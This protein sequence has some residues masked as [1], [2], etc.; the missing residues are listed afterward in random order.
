MYS[1]KKIE[2]LVITNNPLK[3]IHTP[4]CGGSY[5]SSILSKLHIPNKGHGQALKNENATTFTVI[6]NPVERFESL[7]NYRLNE[8]NIRND[9]PAR[10]RYVYRNKNM[11]LNK[12]VSKMTNAEI[13]G[14]KPF[15]T[16]KYWTKNV[17]II[18]TIENLPETLGYFNYKYDINSFEKQ[19]VSVKTRGKFSL[20]TINRIKRLYRNDMILYNKIAKST[21]N[22]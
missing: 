5:V 15:Y 4:K 11:S 2:E 10:L 19:N 1:T 20:K 12:I 3:F 22:L 18:I 7:L 17:N 16:L 21:F 14:F 6:R 9:W 13:L 8:K